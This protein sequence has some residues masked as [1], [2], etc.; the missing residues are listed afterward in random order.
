MPKALELK[1]KREATKKGLSGDRKDAYVYG[2]L[3]KIEKAKTQKQKGK[4]K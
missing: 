4:G 1:L 2:T 3:N